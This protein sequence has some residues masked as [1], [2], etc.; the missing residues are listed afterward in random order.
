MDPVLPEMPPSRLKEAVTVTLSP[1]VVSPMCDVP[2]RSSWYVRPLRLV[3]V[4]VSGRS[5][6]PPCP[7]GGVEVAESVTA[8]A[9]GS[10]TLKVAV[11]AGE[12]TAVGGLTVA[13]DPA[14]ERVTVWPGT[15]F[16]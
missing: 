11:P 15:G 5:V 12:V 2:V 3:K 4:T 6:T 16:A 9:A 14:A 8:W 7:V 13:L 1:A 10:V